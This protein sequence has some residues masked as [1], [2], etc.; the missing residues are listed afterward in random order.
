VDII[1]GLA[2]A[3]GKTGTVSVGTPVPIKKAQ[4]GPVSGPGT[5]TSDSIAAWL[6]DGE[7]VARAKVVRQP[8][9][10]AFLHAFNA[11]GMDAVRRWGAYAFADGGLVSQ[12]PSLQ[13]SPVFNTVAAP[14]T[15]SPMQLGLRLINQVSPGLFEEYMDDPGSDTTII[16]K[17]SRNAAAIRQALEL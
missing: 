3:A 8:G 5:S 4:G 1:G 16:N 15:A 13:R 17:I 7:F 9:A 2:G 12:M 6:S 11:I 10:L 14:P